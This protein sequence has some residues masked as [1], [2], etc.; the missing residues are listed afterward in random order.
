[1]LTERYDEQQ[2]GGEPDLGG[3]DDESGRGLGGPQALRDAVQQRLRVV[4]VGNRDAAGQR[5]QPH[6]S[7]GQHHR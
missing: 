3:G 6:K 4:N 2:A 1:M 7:A 5:Q